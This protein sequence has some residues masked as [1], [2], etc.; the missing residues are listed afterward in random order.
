MKE[1]GYHI[2]YV[3][4]GGK[5]NNIWFETRLEMIDFL[6]KNL[7]EYDLFSVNDIIVDKSRLI[8]KNKKVYRY[9]KL[10]KLN[11]I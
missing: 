3:K 6:F 9:L 11:E 8:Q 2:V 4:S 10:R 7:S 5:P 1:E